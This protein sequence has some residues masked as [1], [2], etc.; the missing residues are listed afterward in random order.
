MA[1]TH[2][3][4]LRTALFAQRISPALKA[5]AAIVTGDAR[6][7]WEDLKS[8]TTQASQEFSALRGAR[9]GLVHRGDGLSWAALTA[10]DELRADV[11]LLNPAL[12]TEAQRQ[13]VQ[14]FRW[15]AIISGFDSQPFENAAAG[16]GESSVIILTSGTSG[17][18]K[19]VRHNWASLSRPVRL[20]AAAEPPVWLQSY[21]P[22][23][24]AGIQVSLQCL[25][26]GGTLVSPH[27]D[28][29]VDEI[30]DMLLR[31]RVEFA[32]ATPSYWRRLLLFGD[33]GKLQSAPLKQITLGGE[34]I[35]QHVLDLLRATLPNT[36]IVHIYATSELG[37]CFSVTDGKAGFPAG[38]V[39]STTADGVELKIEDD[40]LLVRSPNAMLGYDR[41]SDD[42]HGDDKPSD[43]RSRPASAGRNEWIATG[44]LVRRSGDRYVFVG[45]RS[46]VINV[47]GNKVYPQEVEPVLRAVPGVADVR[48]YARQSSLVGQLVAAQIV[49]ARLEEAEAVKA[50]VMEAALEKLAPHQRPRVIELVERIELSAAGKVVR[51]AT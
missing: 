20:A 25:L 49:P 34:A 9:I 44:D 7:T 50:K 8:L 43:D 27:P 46:D 18:P 35:D 24:Y 2:L 26:N 48:V 16:S 21:L 23:L 12:A 1:S 41:P 42:R 10:L 29:D 51:T 28:A 39:G 45:R 22:N 32:S 14:E 31:E 19:A 6:W 36:R 13:L 33:T 3:P 38:W 15:A 5:Q 47:G 4:S 11:F 30:I 37:R 40:E 17:R